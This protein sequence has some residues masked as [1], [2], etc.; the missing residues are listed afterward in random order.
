MRF[1]LV[2]KISNA[3]ALNEGAISTSKNISLIAS[4]VALSTGAL[5][6]N[7]PPKALSG[8]PANALSHASFTD[9]LEAIPQTL[10]CL[11]M[12]KTTCPLFSAPAG[13]LNS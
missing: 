5:Q 9:F 13:E 12:A 2:V 8:S 3:S 7:T 11:M 4:A 1:F 6:I 10:V